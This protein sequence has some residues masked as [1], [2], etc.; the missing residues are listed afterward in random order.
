MAATVTGRAARR[1][2]SGSV[3]IDDLPGVE[4][5]AWIQRGLQRAHGRNFGAGPRDFKVG[6]TLQPDPMLGG[7]RAGDA[8]QWLVDAALHFIEGR[9]V[10]VDISGS[11]RDVQIA[12]SDMPKHKNLRARHA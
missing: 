1:K 2:C 6:L 10:S 5:A 12:V 8:A 7:D 4:Y 3:D 11:N 9:G